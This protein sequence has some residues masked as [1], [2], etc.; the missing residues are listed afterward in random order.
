[1]KNNSQCGL[2][3]QE[4]VHLLFGIKTKQKWNVFGLSV[5][6]NQLNTQCCQNSQ[7]QCLIDAWKPIDQVLLLLRK[8]YNFSQI[9]KKDY[10]GQ[11]HYKQKWNLFYIYSVIFCSGRF[12]SLTNLKIAP[13]QKKILVPHNEPTSLMRLAWSPESSWILKKFA[14]PLNTHIAKNRPNGFFLLKFSRTFCSFM[15]TSPNLWVHYVGLL[16]SSFFS[17]KLFSLDFW[18]T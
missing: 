1:M 16:I 17:T 3:S 12:D 2:C 14:Q 8:V 10:C 4:C 5:A 13:P 6:K 18:H 15:L 11:T 9:K 7:K